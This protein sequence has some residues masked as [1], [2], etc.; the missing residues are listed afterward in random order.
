MILSRV[1]ITNYKQYGGNQTIEIP[2]AGTVGVIGTN[3]VGKTTLFEAIEWA[4]Y[5]PSTIKAADVRPRTWRGNTLVVVELD[6]PATGQQYV[7]ERELGKGSAKARIYRRDAN[8]YEEKIVD[9]AAQVTQY[10]ANTLIG[11]EHSAFVATFFTRQKEL[12]F[13]NG[14]P[15]AR[16]R[17]VGKLL[18]LEIIRDAQERIAE[19]RKRAQADAR[20]YLS[21]SEEQAKERD[22]AAELVSADGAIAIA[23]REVAE[24][25]GAL[26]IAHQQVA[27]AQMQLAAIEKLRDDDASLNEQ[28]LQKQRE[29]DLAQQ[30]MM[31][32]TQELERLEALERER[33]D[34]LPIASQVEELTEKETAH[35]ERRQ[36]AL[37]RRE[38]A[39]ALS[40]IDL[41]EQGIQA[42]IEQAITDTPPPDHN[43]LW[44]TTDVTQAVAWAERIR[45]DEIEARTEAIQHAKAV[46]DNL[47]QEQKRLARFLDRVAVLQRQM[48]DATADGD[49][50]IRIT[51][52]DARLQQVQGSL[53]AVETTRKRLQTELQKN[54]RILSNLEHQHEG[55]VC[56]TCHRPFTADD[57]AHVTEV[58]RKEIAS[59]RDQLLVVHQQITANDEQLRALQ[60]ERQRLIETSKVLDG[61]RSSLATGQQYVAD[62]QA[63][64]QQLTEQLSAAIVTAGLSGPPTAEDIDLARGQL[65][66]WQQIVNALKV[67]KRALAE[68]P[69]LAAERVP[70]TEE[71]A[72]LGEVVYDEAAHRT[73]IE[74]LNQARQAQITALRIDGEL[75][76]KAT[77][78]QSKETAARILG[79]ARQTMATLQDQRSRLGF[80]PTTLLTAQNEHN[81]A[82]EHERTATQHHFRQ[83]T[84][85]RD[86]E[87]ARTRITDDRKRLEQLTR[88]AEIKRR[89]ADDLDL[90]YKEF[91]E[92]ERYAAAWYA[93]RLG[94]ITSDLVA[95]VTDGK[96]DRVDFDNNFSIQVY[97]RDDEKYPYE[98][99]SGGERDAIALCARIALSRLIGGASANPPG[100]LVLDEVFGSLDLERRQR[101]LEMLGMI[102]HADHQFQQVFIISHVDDIRTSPILDEIW[103]VKETG[104]GISQI[105]V[106]GAGTDIGE[107]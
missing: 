85:L 35:S 84:Q 71:V 23:Q 52:I 49:P 94:E 56:P 53:A 28:I 40:A 24:A 73:V 65:T 83:Q 13:F 81:R 89:E 51:A 46:S 63:A 61:V 7:V 86:A 3:G 18:G 92:F 58:F 41:R 106:V 55:E 80:D 67:I 66:K 39:Q 50:A 74:Q 30:Q 95:Q 70:V 12:G 42:A 19:V 37:R 4:L 97:D 88:T 60:P 6:D 22:F 75:S 82:L 29:H 9:G 76:R 64:V 17:E 47:D 2:Q 98:T 93:P 16:R 91:S 25:Q 103:Q 43:P 32:A 20:S 48:S 10:V 33:I 104:D 11:L 34:L 68:L 36:R 69:R 87:T 72:A 27:A 44:S 31:S 101:L 90:M 62:Q 15:T 14:S 102:T 8:G 100:F 5:S 96:Y 45:L 38:L 59:L 78:E 1:H 105:E 107:I 54:E 26:E 79:G 21:M 57:A 77:V 99:F